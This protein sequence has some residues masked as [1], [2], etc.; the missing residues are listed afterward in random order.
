MTCSTL[1]PK[2]ELVTLDIKKIHVIIV[3]TST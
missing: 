3:L 1:Q 2:N